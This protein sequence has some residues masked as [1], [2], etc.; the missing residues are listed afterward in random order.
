MEKNNIA[1]KLIP[2]DPNRYTFLRIFTGLV[3]LIRGINFIFVMVN[4]KSMIQQADVAILTQNSAALSTLIAFLNIACGLFIIVGFF[5]RLSAIIQIPIL[6]VATFF[7]NIRHLGNN[8]FEFIL[9]LV[10]LVLAIMVAYKG[11]GRFS[12]DEY[13]RR[14]AALDR[15]G[16]NRI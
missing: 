10:T 9:S 14:G 2:A 7:V 4:L 8:S 3:I 5:A 6:V 12:A 1:D 11:S 15:A 13:F 16:E